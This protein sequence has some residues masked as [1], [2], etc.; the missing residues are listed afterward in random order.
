[1]AAHAL[2]SERGSARRVCELI[3]A[4]ECQLTVSWRWNVRRE[5]LRNFAV[6]SP[7]SSRSC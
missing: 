7:R 4:D 3:S 1:M 5:T 2:A 6:R